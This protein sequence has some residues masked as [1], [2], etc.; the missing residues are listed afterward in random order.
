MMAYSPSAPTGMKRIFYPDTE[1]HMQKFVSR[2]HIGLETN[3]SS[4]KLIGVLSR[5]DEHPI[6]KW[7][8]VGLTYDSEQLKTSP[9][10]FISINTDDQGVF[11]TCL[12]NEFALVACALEKQKNPDGSPVYNQAQ[13][14]EWLEN[15]RRMGLEQCFRTPLYGEVVS[16]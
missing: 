3:P 1:T 15:I 7:Y 6:Q 13:I 9:Q 16:T 2:K 12:E 4:N 11:N 8:N 10:S 14:Y 5:Y